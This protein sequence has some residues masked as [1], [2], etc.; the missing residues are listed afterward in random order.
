MAARPDR[1]D[2]EVGARISRAAR[3]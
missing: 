2:I 1:R 3:T